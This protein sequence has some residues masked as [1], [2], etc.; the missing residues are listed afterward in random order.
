M[1]HNDPTLISLDHF[2]GSME[3]LWHLI[4]KRELDIYAVP[5]NSITEKY[6]TH[7]NTLDSFPVDDG[8]EFIGTMASLMLFKSKKLLP[9]QDKIVESQEEI[10]D[11]H[12][13]I[14]HHL[15]DY[16]RFKEAAQA[17]A[18]RERQQ[19]AFHTRGITEVPAPMLPNG[20]GIEHLSLDDLASLFQIALA[21]AASQRGL[22][23]KE[24]WRVQDKIAWIRELLISLQKIEAM[25]LFPETACREELIVTFL[26]ILE[27]MKMGEVQVGRE[28]KTQELVLFN[29][30]HI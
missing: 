12:F 30:T 16:C 8:A 20:L 10:A 7:F 18:E 28:T 27:L 14:I 24:T 29:A 22:I 3:L 4:Q 23:Q 6:R 21:K 13:S 11:P 2:V 15:I 17:L 1:K 5:L 25:V 26:A 9:Q 19:N